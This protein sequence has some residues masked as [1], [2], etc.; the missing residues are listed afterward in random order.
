MSIFFEGVFGCLGTG[1]EQLW[2]KRRLLD[3]R[4]QFAKGAFAAAL[5]TEYMGGAAGL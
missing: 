1:E 4:A 2:A 5:A 3:K